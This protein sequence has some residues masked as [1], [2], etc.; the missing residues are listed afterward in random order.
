[1][2]LIIAKAKGTKDNGVSFIREAGI[3][4]GLLRMNGMLWWKAKA[5]RQKIFGQS[6]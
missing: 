4:F 1:M 6:K 5:L 3:H 2:D